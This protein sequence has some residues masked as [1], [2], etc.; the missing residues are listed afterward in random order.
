LR[1]REKERGSERERGKGGNERERGERGRKMI[2]IVANRRHIYRLKC[3]KFDLAEA[4]PQTPVS[5]LTGFKGPGVVFIRGGRGRKR[6]GT[7]GEGGKGR[8]GNGGRKIIKIAT[9]RRHYFKA[10]MHQ[11]RFRLALRPRPRWGS[12]QRSPRPLAGFK[13]VLLLRRG[14]GR[15]RRE[16]GKGRGGR[17]R[18][19]GREG[20]KWEGKGGGR[21]GG[22]EGRAVPS[23]SF[24]PGYGP[25]D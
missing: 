22:R 25:G 19:R 13:G 11:I 4:P 1:R 14:R 2:K 17:E 5:E 10:K 23:R 6:E 21:D 8:G 24:N 7:G 3:S 12:S 9:N 20:G 18:E 16:R 15:G